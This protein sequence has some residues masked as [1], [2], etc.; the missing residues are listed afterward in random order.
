MSFR[1][2]ALTTARFDYVARLFAGRADPF[3]RTALVREA[4]GWVTA[5]SSAAAADHRPRR[6]LGLS[7]ARRAHSLTMAGPGAAGCSTDRPGRHLRPAAAAGAGDRLLSDCVGNAAPAVRVSPSAAGPLSGC[8]ARSSS[9]IP[10]SAAMSPVS[11]RRQRVKK[12]SPGSPVEVLETNG[13]ACHRWRHRAAL[14]HGSG[15]RWAPSSPR[16]SSQA[17]HGED[18]LAALPPAPQTGLLS[19]R[20]RS[21][22][23]RPCRI[24]RSAA[25]PPPGADPEPVQHCPRRLIGADLAAPAAGCWAEMPSLAVA[26][27][28]TQAWNHHRQRCARLVEDSP[29]R[30]RG[31]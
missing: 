7:S 20:C 2:T 31:P 13:P 23:P 25:R 24:N 30:H 3:A 1:G 19:R 11:G 28:A 8:S 15:T 26:L 9:M 21:H 29:S 10:T 5:R 12:S 18:L 6:R 16:T 14:D 17:I 4:G 22:R 27:T